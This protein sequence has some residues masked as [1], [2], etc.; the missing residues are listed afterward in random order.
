MDRYEL[1]FVDFFDKN[2]NLA[3]RTK[4]FLFLLVRVT[5]KF[6]ALHNLVP[7]KSEISPLPFYWTVLSALFGSEFEVGLPATLNLSECLYCACLQVI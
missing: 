7:D 5:Y 2:L 6:C 3:K 1:I 4:L